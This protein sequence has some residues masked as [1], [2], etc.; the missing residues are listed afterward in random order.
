MRSWISLVI[1]SRTLTSRSKIAGA[2]AIEPMIT[3][4]SFAVETLGGIGFLVCNDP[5]N[6]GADGVNDDSGALRHVQGFATRMAAQVIVTVTDDG[7]SS[8]RLRRQ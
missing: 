1:V 6:A 2:A 7:G 3:Q 4:G 5:V 8:G